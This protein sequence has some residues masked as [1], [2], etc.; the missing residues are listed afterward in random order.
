[1][2]DAQPKLVKRYTPFASPPQELPRPEHNL[3]ESEQRHYNAVLKH[4]QELQAIKTGEELAE[5]LPLTLHERL[6]LTQEQFLRYLRATKWHPQ[7]AIAR[8]TETLV[9]RRLYGCSGTNDTLTAEVVLEEN[10]TGKQFIL[11]YDNDNRP[12]LYLRNGYQNTKPLMRQVQ[13]LVFMLEQ[14]ITFMPPGQDTL[15]L[16]IDF[17]A[18]PIKG[19]NSK[20]PPL[21]ITKKCLHIL[22]H[23]YPERL[24]KGLFTNLTWLFWGFLKVA[25]PFIDPYTR[26][27]TIYDT[28]FVNYVPADMLDKEFKGNLDFEYQHDVYWPEML[29]LAEHKR[30]VYMKN[31]ERLGGEIGLSEYDLRQEIADA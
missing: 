14:V 1:M 8:I 28:P 18:A 6:W 7:Q 30:G 11:G 23:H 9:W 22:Q 3:L 20:F 29:R 13:H 2:S 25:T 17:K 26:L 16:L 24:G 10:E 31:F 12:C 5:T 15:A 27:K 4:F 21:G 19:T